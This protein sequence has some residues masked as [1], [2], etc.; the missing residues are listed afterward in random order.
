M[1][2]EGKVCVHE[3]MYTQGVSLSVYRENKRVEVVF[4]TCQ[5]T[6]D[7]HSEALVQGLFVVFSL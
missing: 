6:A 3:Y 1:L 7:V 4:Q 5:V 2:V